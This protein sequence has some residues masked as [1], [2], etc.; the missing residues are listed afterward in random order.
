M[1]G[2]Y[3]T[4]EMAGR[5]LNKMYGFNQKL[6]NLYSSEGLDIKADI[7]RRNILMSSIQEKEFSKELSKIY[8]GVINDGRSGQPDI[9]IGEIDT[10]LECKLTSPHS[11]KTWALQCDYATLQK[12]GSLDFLYMLVDRDFENAAVLYFKGLTIEDFHPPASGSR[13]KSRMNK[14]KAMKKCTSLFG[15]VIDKNQEI[16]DRA[17]LIVAD[18]KK[19]PYQKKKALER[20]INW[21]RKEKHYSFKLERIIGD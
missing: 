11:N 4:E 5:A 3:I 14:S 1:S 15:D 17:K 10:E 12:K 6:S 2:S 8:S 13:G 7:G 9:I 19:P 16:I 21:G 18:A 20:I